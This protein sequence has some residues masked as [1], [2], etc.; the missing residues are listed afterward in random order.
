MQF[1][2]ICICR[3]DPSYSS[4]GAVSRYH[5]GFVG[6]IP[7][8]ET[9]FRWEDRMLQLHH[10]ICRYRLEC[11][12][13]ILGQHHSGHA[14]FRHCARFPELRRR[15]HCWIGLYRP[16]GRTSVRKEE[17]ACLSECVQPYWRIERR[18]HS[19]AG[20]CYIG[21]GGWETTIQP[22]V[23]LCSSGL[24]HHHVTDGD[25]LP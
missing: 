2:S 20:S 16:L 12:R 24:R 6:Y 5:Y 7:E 1:R 8:R 9:Q 15:Y 21:T 19:R 17:H 22:V 4:W 14:A 11:A 3:R 25:Y 23:S 10:W 13:T 18:C